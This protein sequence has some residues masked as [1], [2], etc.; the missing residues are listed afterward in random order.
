MKC[1]LCG[2]EFDIEQAEL[3]CRGC[4]LTPNCH[5]IRCPRCGYET[6]P[7]AALIKWLR[8]LRKRSTDPA[9]GDLATLREKQCL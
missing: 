8:R 1:G 5:L 2:H 6:P 7:E 3:A 9:T 4:P